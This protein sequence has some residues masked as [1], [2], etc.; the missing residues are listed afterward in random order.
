MLPAEE[1]RSN[2]TKLML[3]GAAIGFVYGVAMR[4]GI[5]RHNL[6]SWLGVMSVAFLLVVPFVMG[7]VT[8]FVAER[9]ESMAG[10][11]WVVL[12]W[13]PLFGGLAA[14]GVLLIEGLICLAMFAP[15]GMG[16]AS[17]GGILGGFLGRV[18]RGRRSSD[19]IAGCVLFLPFLVGPLEQ[20][21]LYSP[22]IHETK[23]YIDIS[24]PAD[25]VWTYS[26]VRPL[27]D[28]G[29]CSTGELNT[30]I[31]RA[32]G[33]GGTHDEV[34]GEPDDREDDGEGDQNH[35]RGNAESWTSHGRQSFT[36]F[37]RRR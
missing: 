29:D 16:C 2:L 33:L 30:S 23:T 4:V 17:L 15:I 7:F 27:F 11:Y 32:E 18:A 9:R 21:V 31:N 24:A 35:A 1:S 20:Q 6:P 28:D 5:H 13:V 34:D 25:V 8:V 19:M 12:P 14:T 37:G 36:Q 3:Y 26:G 10:W 22:E